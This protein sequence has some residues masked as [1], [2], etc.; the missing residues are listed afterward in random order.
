[1]RRANPPKQL[2]REAIPVSQYLCL[3][4]ALSETL[5]DFCHSS[6]LARPG[7]RR[8]GIFHDYI[9]LAALTLTTYSIVGLSF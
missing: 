2:T 6:I 8:V 3:A 7:E 1:M 5:F 9:G 4:F